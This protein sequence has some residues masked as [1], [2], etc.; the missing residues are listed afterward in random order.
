[1]IA[2]PAQAEDVGFLAVLKG[3]E[4]HQTSAHVV[5]LGE[6]KNWHRTGQIANEG[7]HGDPV[8]VFEAFIVGTAP[9]ALLSAS[10][11]PPVGEAVPMTP[12]DDPNDTELGFEAGA[13][14]PLELDTQWPDGTYTVEVSRKNDGLLAIALDLDS[15]VFPPVPQVLDFDTLQA[16]DPAFDHLI[17][18]SPMGGTTSDFILLE[19][20]L[21]SADGQSSEGKVFSSGMPFS[22]DSLDGTHTEVQIPAGT[23]EPG[24]DYHGEL[25]FV[26]TSEV[27]TTPVRAVAGTYKMTGFGIRTAATPNTPLNARFLRANPPF[28]GYGPRDTVLALHFSHPMSTSPAH[29]TVTWTRDG[30]PFSPAVQYH[31]SFDNR[32]LFCEFPN[33]LP[34]NGQIGWALADFHDAAGF[35]AAVLGDGWFRT[36]D[37]EPDTPPDIDFIGLFKAR[38]FL[39]IASAP[40]PTGRY[41][42]VAEIDTNAPNRLK[43]AVVLAMADDTAR[44]LFADPWHGDEY[45]TPGE[46]ASKASLDR[47]WPNG[48]YM[49]TFSSVSDGAN[50][51]Y[52][53][54]RT[55]A[56]DTYPDAPVVTNLADLQALDPASAFT[57]T[58]QPLPGWNGDLD[59]LAPGDGAAIL[60]IVDESGH[61]VFS[62]DD[63][64]V[65]S[66][67]AEIPAGRLAPGRRYFASLAFYR[68]TDRETS[69]YPM[70][71]VAGFASRTVFTL[72]TAGQRLSAVLRIERPGIPAILTAAHLEPETSY[73]VEASQDLRRWAQIVDFWSPGGATPF[74]WR[75]EDWDAQFLNQRFYRLRERTATEPVAIPVAIQGTVWNDSRRTSPAAGAVVGTSLDAHT[76]V[77]DAE[78]R[79]FLTTGTPSP[80]GPYTIQVTADG[81][82]RQFGPF[83]WGDQPRGQHFEMN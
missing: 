8:H 66:Q 74:V 34:A 75:F 32:V 5:S 60:E 63:G 51:G 80:V 36:G 73:M 12:G 17:R 29:R 27:K 10:V 35:P 11:T 82:V 19:I 76:T 71:G 3:R 62:G 50:V 70:F 28:G 25:I 1:M 61:H 16:I 23:F 77:T 15:T 72:Q 43:H 6:W 41:E 4:F 26:K 46:Y 14:T 31:W 58:W 22:P 67:S 40:V 44:P 39:Q 83:P 38:E 54:L 68:I 65:T 78:G 64:G 79:F 45:A 37:E 2:T 18:W 55:G 24:R 42:A 47:F 52:F 69:G 30:A 7:G 59:S 48:D 57:I 81:Q 21:L 9:G 33:L 49:I 56:T 13:R 20:E 53:T